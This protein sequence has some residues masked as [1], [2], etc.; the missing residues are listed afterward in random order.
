[1]LMHRNRLVVAV[2]W[3]GDVGGLH[4]H[5]CYGAGGGCP[6]CLVGGV[7]V[8]RCV[9]IL[10]PAI[11]LVSWAFFCMVVHTCQGVVG[12]AGDVVM[13]QGGWVGGDTLSLSATWWSWLWS[14]SYMRSV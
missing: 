7:S 3:Q 8:S 2:T 14:Y 12:A 9:C 10:S 1:M 11:V 5:S 4:T 6:C 13:H